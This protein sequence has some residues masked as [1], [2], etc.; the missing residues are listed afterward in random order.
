MSEDRL[1][2]SQVLQDVV[3][4]VECINVKL[5]NV[6]SE[7]PWDL[8]KYLRYVNFCKTSSLPQCGKQHHQSNG[9]WA[10]GLQWGSSGIDIVC[11][12]RG[13]SMSHGGQGFRSPSCSGWTRKISV[14]VSSGGAGSRERDALGDGLMCECLWS[15][16]GV[17]VSVGEWGTLWRSYEMLEAIRWRTVACVLLLFLHYHPRPFKQSRASGVLRNT[18][19]IRTLLLFLLCMCGLLLFLG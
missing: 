17:S 5:T 7:P 11:R 13:V 15:N 9:G 2:I 6:L 10:G 8:L 19:T 16:E 1:L 14:T 12:G 3:F 18:A 4:I